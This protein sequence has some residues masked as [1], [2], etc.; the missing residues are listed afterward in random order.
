MPQWDHAMVQQ[1]VHSWCHPAGPGG[2]LV[3][4]DLLPPSHKKLAVAVSSA[5]AEPLQGVV[6]PGVN[7][8]YHRLPMPGRIDFALLSR[9]VHRP[10]CVCY[11]LS[12][13]E[14][15]TASHRSGLPTNAAPALSARSNPREHSHRDIATWLGAF[16]ARAAINSTPVATSQQSRRCACTAIQSGAATLSSTQTDLG[17]T[18]GSLTHPAQPMEAVPIVEAASG[19]QQATA[20]TA[21]LTSQAPPPSMPRPKHSVVAQIATHIQ[22]IT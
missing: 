19:S 16:H 13:G 21:V 18:R 10:N 20:A 9:C 2:P 5:R 17:N 7:I 12:A 11:R 8:C 22:T 4:K 15:F 14:V 3:L 6:A 1:A